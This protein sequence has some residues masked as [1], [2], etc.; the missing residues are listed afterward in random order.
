VLVPQLGGR[1]HL[2]EV[3]AAPEAGTGLRG[4]RQGGQVPQAGHLHGY[5]QDH[6]G[7]VSTYDH[8]RLSLKYVAKKEIYYMYQR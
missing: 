4:L 2:L 6:R 3:S 7:G 1:D 5:L 8:S